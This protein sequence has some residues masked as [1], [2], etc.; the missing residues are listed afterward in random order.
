ME[1]RV[2]GKP[3]REYQHKGQLWVEGRKGT[4]FTLRFRNLTGKRMLVI[5]SVDGLSIMDGEKCSFDSSGYILS[6]YQHIDVPGWRLDNSEVAKFVFGKKGKS[7]AAKKG[8]PMDVGVIGVATFFEKE[9]PAH[10]LLRVQSFN[11]SHS[12]RSTLLG[13]NLMKGGG[14]RGMSSGAGGMSA[15]SDH[16]EGASCYNVQNASMDSMGVESSTT[17]QVEPQGQTRGGDSARF[18]DQ[19]VSQEIGTEFGER[20]AHAV[21]EVPFEKATEKPEETLSIRYD[22]RRNLRKRGV[23]LDQKPR[24][25]KEPNAFPGEPKGCEPPAGWDG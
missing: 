13:D 25:T 7:Y 14:G 10:R 24:V 2:H 23:D 19:P 15:G 17:C 5:P 20:H 4:D 8:E 11:L 12:G 1:V 6:P 9:Y 18:I 21:V 16:I 3:V 22:S